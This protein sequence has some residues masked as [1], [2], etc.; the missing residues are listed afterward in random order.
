VNFAARHIPK[1]II[2]KRIPYTS[3]ITN[4]TAIEKPATEGVKELI[5]LLQG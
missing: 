4:L 5:E 1:Y 3:E 2:D